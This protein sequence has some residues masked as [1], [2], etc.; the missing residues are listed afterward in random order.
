MTIRPKGLRLQGSCRTCIAYVPNVVPIGTGICYGAPPQM[1]PAQT[2][3]GSVGFI[4]QQPTVQA[5]HVCMQWT[6]AGNG[7]QEDVSTQEQ[8][9]AS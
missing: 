1:F 4:N 8:G 5:E 7:A 9:K 3:V 2:A 6:R